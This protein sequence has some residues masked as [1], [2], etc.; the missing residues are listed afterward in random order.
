M[1]PMKNI[2]SVDRKKTIDQLLMQLCQILV[3]TEDEEEFHEKSD[4]LFVNI[5]PDIT[6]E[7]SQVF[8]TLFNTAAKKEP[9]LSS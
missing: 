6:K 2:E 1:T 4:A 5:P 7:V 8:A 9:T 3:D